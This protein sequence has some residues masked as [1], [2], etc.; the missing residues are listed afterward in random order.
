[1]KY[2]NNRVKV[3]RN[4]DLA[5]IFTLRSNKVGVID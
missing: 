5:S 2:Q 4:S 3:A 1:M